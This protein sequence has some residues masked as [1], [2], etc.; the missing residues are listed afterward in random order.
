MDELLKRIEQRFHHKVKK[1]T[2][3][4]NLSRKVKAGDT[5]DRPAPSTYGLLKFRKER[6]LKA[7]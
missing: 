4:G 3:V 2:L 6:Q 7:G 5:F 1:T